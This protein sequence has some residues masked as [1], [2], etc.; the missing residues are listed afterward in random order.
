M[1]NEEIIIELKELNKN[2]ID[3]KEAILL[4]IQ[5]YQKFWKTFYVP[6]KVA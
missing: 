2:I 5:E 4:F 3:V 1:E 6:R